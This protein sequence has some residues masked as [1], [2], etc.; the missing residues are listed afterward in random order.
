[1]TKNPL[2]KSTKLKWRIDGTIEEIKNSNR[3]SISEQL[4]KI[5]Q[6]KNRLVNLLE[7]RNNEL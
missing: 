4:S 6:L 2:F 1:M 3:A 5:S 7:Y